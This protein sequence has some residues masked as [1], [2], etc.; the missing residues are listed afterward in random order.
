MGTLTANPLDGQFS[1]AEEDK[2]VNV[3]NLKIQDTIEKSD[4]KDDDSYAE[5]DYEASDEFDEEYDYW[6]ENIDAEWVGGGRGE[7]QASPK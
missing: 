5:Y 2:E 7:V 4:E 3:T 1:D 6:D